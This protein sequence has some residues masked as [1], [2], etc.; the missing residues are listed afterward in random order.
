[1]AL[2]GRRKWLNE[3][4]FG[5]DTPAG[6]NF[7][8]FLIWAILVSVGLV[9]LASV[10]RIAGR[11]GETLFALEWFFTALFTVEYFL[12]IYC[13]VE[14]R[15][16]IFSFYGIVD[17]LAILPS[18]L[19]LVYTGASYLLVVRLLRV[20]RIFRVLKLVRYLRDANVLLRSFGLARRKILV[21]YASVLVMCVIF[22]ALMFLVEG[23]GHGFTSIPKSV[24]W[25]IV[26][27]TTV[28]YG[29]IS[30]HT[31]LG[32][33]IASMTM[34]I[35]YSIIAVPTGIV[36][37]ELASELHQERSLRRCDNCSRAGHDR[38][39]EYCKYCGYKLEDLHAEL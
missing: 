5:T 4:I 11:Y 33:A 3:V 9:L 36:T 21:F 32:Q 38:D 30:P 16:Y 37:A 28:G 8:V 10:E 15:R 23:P 12:R 39:A 34:L 35:G 7:D 18:Y 6:R 2:T 20:L 26:T 17:L 1:M 13:A 27:I 25:A 24:Y 19:A 14:R 22:G 31:V 29:D